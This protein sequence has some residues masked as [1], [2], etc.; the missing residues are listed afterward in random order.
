MNFHSPATRNRVS[1]AAFPAHEEALALSK[2]LAIPPVQAV[3]QNADQKLVDDAK[4]KADD[5]M[6]AIKGGKSLE[7]QAR[8]NSE[9]VES[10]DRGGELVGA[11]W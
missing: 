4:R 11:G 2:G 1:L 7:E 3:L 6:A 9:D 10:K 5:N 8:A